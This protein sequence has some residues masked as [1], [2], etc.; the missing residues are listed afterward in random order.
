LAAAIY[1]S[2]CSDDSP[3]FIATWYTIAVAAVAAI[4]AFAGSKMLKY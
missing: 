4:G 3:L 1:A 2:H